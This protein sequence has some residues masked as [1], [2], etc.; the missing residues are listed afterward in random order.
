MIALSPFNALLPVPAY[1]ADEVFTGNSKIVLKG[2]GGMIQ[3]DAL[4]ADG[5]YV[6]D[7]PA[8]IYIYQV[9]EAGRMQTGIWAQVA[10]GGIKIHEKVLPEKVHR[11]NV[12]RA[13]TGLEAKPV[14]LTYRPDDEVKKLIDI[15][16]ATPPDNIYHEGQK[17]HRLWRIHDKK[18]MSALIIAFAN[19][20]SVYMADGHHRLAANPF[21]TLSALLMDTDEISVKPYHR[22]IKTNKDLDEYF[23]VLDAV[24]PVLPNRKGY[25][26]LLK[27]KRW[28][29]LI[30]RRSKDYD[31]ETLDA[32]FDY[33]E[34]TPELKGEP[35]KLLFTLAPLH[36]NEVLKAAD[37]GIILPP[38]STW[39]EPKIPYG[40]LMNR[41]DLSI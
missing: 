25:F 19:I 3:L 21:K 38:K 30:A 27:N 18:S 33:I 11:I 37:A 24:E 39:I 20:D 32:M 13:L 28:Y 36:I 23:Q 8:G 7:K 10:T 9:E 4:L 41:H 35:D 2:E 14:L 1:V 16:T 6:R 5:E 40:L 22:L 17:T 29:N 15:I 12:R 31:T 26:G 34:Y